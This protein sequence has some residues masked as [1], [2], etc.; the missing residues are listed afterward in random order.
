MSNPFIHIETD[1]QKAEETGYQKTALERITGYERQP[2]DVDDYTHNKLAQDKIKARNGIAL[3]G[4]TLA[5]GIALAGSGAGSLLLQGGSSA[6]DYYSQEQAL[7]EQK[8]QFNLGLAEQKKVNASNLQLALDAQNWQKMVDDRN[9]DYMV[10]E[11]Q[12]QKQREDTAHQREVAD[13]K[14]AGLSPLAS[15]KGSPTGSV[16][17]QAHGVSPVVPQQDGSSI[18]NL[19]STAINSAGAMAGLRSQL[20]RDLLKTGSDFTRQK[21]QNNFESVMQ[22]ERLDVDFSKFKENLD[23]ERDEAA[24]A[25]AEFIDTMAYKTK[26]LD[27]RINQYADDRTY[28]STRDFK[29]YL[30]DSFGIVNYYEISNEHLLSTAEDNWWKDFKSFESEIAYLTSVSTVSRSNSEWNN[31]GLSG[32]FSLGSQGNVG[33]TTTYNSGTDKTQKIPKGSKTDRVSDSTQSIWNKVYPSFAVRGSGSI[34]EGYSNSTSV[35]K[36]DREFYKALCRAYAME[37]PFPIK[38]HKYKNDSK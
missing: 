20:L 38:K 22:R 30:Y 21:L 7:A 34:G 33:E 16:V 3:A 31:T 8:R 37:H 32:E 23:F 28:Q 36:D 26:E 25:K 5:G 35:S 18:A 24:R 29:N 14:A 17:S 2:F 15:L 27:S 4:L 9:Y 10:A 11:N 19:Y 13:L 1:P 12:L 6:L